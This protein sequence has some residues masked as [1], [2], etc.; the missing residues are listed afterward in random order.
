MKNLFDKL[1]YCLQ[2]Y[3]YSYTYL[4]LVSI[5]SVL[6]NVIPLSFSLIADF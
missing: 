5:Y 3:N 1:T 4:T 2:K 6:T